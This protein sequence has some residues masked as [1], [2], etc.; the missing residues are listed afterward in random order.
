VQ[1]SIAQEWRKGRRLYNQDRVGHWQTPEALLLAVADG[2]GG[3]AGGEIAAQA[4]LDSVA[5]AFSAQARPRLADP[6]VFLQSAVRQ[7]HAAIVR[8][9][10]KA[11]L[12]DAPRTTLVACVVQVGWAYWSFVGDSRLYLI[13]E[14]RVA[15]RTR[16]HTAVQQLIDAGR[17]REE[18]VAAHPDRNKLLR[19]LGGALAPGTEPVAS[20]QLARGDILLVCSDGLWGP[21]SPRQLLMALIGKDPARALPALA[22]LAEAHGGS[23]CDNISAVA[24]QWQE[25]TPHTAPWPT[26]TTRIDAPLMRIK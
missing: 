8:A 26:P 14:G 17:I 19:C 9:S 1:F 7:A 6:R 12:G 22:A 20:A 2:M 10:A 23:G 13:R 18:A 4:A 25:D 24:V 5:S 3:H 21:L 11:G 15:A 16:D